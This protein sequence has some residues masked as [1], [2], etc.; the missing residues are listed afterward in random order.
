MLR[1]VVGKGWCLRCA[2]VAYIGG[3][4]GGIILKKII[5]MLINFVVSWNFNSE[6]STLQGNSSV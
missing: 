5:R 2:L 3:G 4:R 1:G 6:P